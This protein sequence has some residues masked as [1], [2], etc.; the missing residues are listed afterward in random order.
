M[1]EK[2]K[3]VI[4]NTIKREYERVGGD[5][6]KHMKKNSE[7]INDY[8]EYTRKRQD[9][10]DKLLEIM[11]KEYHELI[12]ALEDASNSITS[13]EAEATFKEGLILGVTELDYLSEVGIEIAFI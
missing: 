12:E 7:L 3:N 5:L 1:N 13:I 2:M 4:N 11:P 10:M 6:I 8:R 9:I